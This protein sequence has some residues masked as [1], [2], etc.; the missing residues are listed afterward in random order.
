MIPDMFRA[1]IAFQPL[2]RFM[3]RE[4]IAAGPN[5]KKKPTE[6]INDGFQYPPN[7]RSIWNISGK[8]SKLLTQDW[9]EHR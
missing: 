4:N 9:P 6:Y 2:F 7:P 5:W 1:A 8:I 3:R